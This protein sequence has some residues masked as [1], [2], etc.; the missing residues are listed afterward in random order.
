MDW[1]KNL[2]RESIY[3]ALTVLTSLLFWIA[4]AT[5]IEQ[6]IIAPEYLYARERNGFMLTVGVF[7]FIRLNAW[8]IN[9]NGAHGDRK[10]EPGNRIVRKHESSELHVVGE[11]KEQCG[12]LL[13]RVKHEWMADNQ[14]HEAKEDGSI[15]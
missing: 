1:Q 8:M 3:F 13:A 11:A 12:K 14:Q 6:N 7:Y 2:G 15:S 10:W 5:I 4:I 9:R